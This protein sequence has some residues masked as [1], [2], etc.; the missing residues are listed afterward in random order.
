VDED[1]F[2]SID[3][4]TCW[5]SLAVAAGHGDG[6]SVNGDDSSEDGDDSSEDNWF[7][8]DRFDSID[9]PAC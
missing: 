1:R 9:S 2:D 7:G 4:S 6:N 3:S 5:I 8:E